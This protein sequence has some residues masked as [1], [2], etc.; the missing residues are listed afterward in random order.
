MDGGIEPEGEPA[1]TATGGSRGWIVHG[2]GINETTIQTT[3]ANG[4][5][6]SGK[7]NCHYLQVNFGYEGSGDRYFLVNNPDETATVAAES[8]GQRLGWMSV[9]GR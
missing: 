7:L 1:R 4:N 8:Y 6:T 2:Y 5:I 3:D 9:N